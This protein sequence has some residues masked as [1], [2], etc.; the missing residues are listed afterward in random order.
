MP[1]DS[2]QAEPAP[3]RRSRRLPAAPASVDAPVPAPSRAER[4]RAV[5]VA[6]EST[7]SVTLP[8]DAV[9]IELDLAAAGEEPRDSADPVDTLTPEPVVPA[10]EAEPVL[11]RRARR[12][13]RASVP[14]V[15]HLVVDEI[16]APAAEAI[17]HD[18]AAVE[19]E[20]LESVVDSPA[21]ESLVD[22]DAG[23]APA[24]ADADEDEFE[25]AARLFCF[26]GE[27][28]VAAAPSEP[29]SSAPL[30]ITGPTSSPRAVDVPDAPPSRVWRR[31]PSPSACSA[32]SDSWPSA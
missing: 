1:L 13:R 18:P 20:L 31:H 5:A 12:A 19:P 32:S 15:E 21:A 10:D 25:R 30:T 23:D 28:P 16:P 29:A 17:A 9:L 27:T 3:T 7:A 8:G 24:D 22:A 14:A 11:T 4:R 26:T 2:P 6:V